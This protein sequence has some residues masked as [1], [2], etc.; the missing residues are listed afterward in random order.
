MTHAVAYRD[1]RWTSAGGSSWKLRMTDFVAR[2]IVGCARSTADV[3]RMARSALVSYAIYCSSMSSETPWITTSLEQWCASSRYKRCF[4]VMTSL[5]VTITGQSRSSVSLSNE[6]QAYW[7]NW[8]RSLH[9]I[10]RHALLKRRS[11][12]STMVRACTPDR[13]RTRLVCW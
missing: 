5:E 9:E 8:S 13:V 1:L 11:T 12:A 4:L 7:F 6:S 2:R 10:F 3:I